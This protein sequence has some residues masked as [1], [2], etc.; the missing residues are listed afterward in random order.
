MTTERKAGQSLLPGVAE[1]RGDLV[2]VILE[3]RRLLSLEYGRDFSEVFALSSIL[4]EQGMDPE[5]RRDF[6]AQYSGAIFP[7]GL[8]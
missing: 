5:A 7:T 1:D 3:R 6:I 2:R 8:V 4:A